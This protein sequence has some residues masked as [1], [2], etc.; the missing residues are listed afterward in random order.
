MVLTA[1]DTI[2]RNVV[3]AA[4]TAI[5]VGYR[6][7]DTAEMYQT[8]GEL[9]IAIKEMIDEGVVKRED[10]FVTTKISTEYALAEKKI[11]ISLKKL[12]LDY[13]DFPLLKGPDAD[14]QAAWASMQAVKASG[15][16]RSIGVS[17]FEESHLATTLAGPQTQ[18]VPSTNQIEYH[19]YMQ[20]RELVRFSKDCAEGRGIAVSA[21][22][23]M[24]PVTRN[25]NPG[26][27][28][29]QTLTKIA[30]RHGVSVGLV[31]FRWCIDQGVV[32]VTTSLREERMKEYL[33][34]F[35]FKLS[36]DEV[37]DIS[38]AGIE[39]LPN[40]EELVPRAVQYHRRL[41]A[42]KELRKTS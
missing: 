32:V 42:E 25:P 24:H 16:A 29:D 19:P 15:K 26:G 35:D 38:D 17:N 36:E 22:G 3:E 20:H 14:L 37:K 7:L 21:Y 40:G 13:V 6:H 31:C 30:E 18:I 34:V 28:L 23:A 10:L 4:K 9:G 2:D 33:R 12:G 8:E 41:E 1:S 5:R 27:P 39:S 11:E